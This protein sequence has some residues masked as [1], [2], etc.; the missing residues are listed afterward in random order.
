MTNEP[1]YDEDI[2]NLGYLN[3]VIEDTEESINIEYE[4]VSR[5]YGSQ[6]VPP[7]YKGDTWI[8]G[9][10]VYTCI[11]DR[12]IGT[13]QSS[14]WTTESG[15]KE[16]AS[17]KN[18]V[19]LAQPSN[20]RP[21]DMWI[22]QTDSD[23]IAGKKGEM[24][25]STFGRSTYNASD[26]INMLGYGKIISINEAI[27]N[28]NN[29]INTIIENIS[30]GTIT[31]FYSNS[32][33][34]N[35]ITNDLWYVTG[36]VQGYEENKLYKYNGS[37]WVWVDNVYIL[38][39]FEEVNEERLV[40]DGKIQSFYSNT[41][42]TNNLGVGDL[43][44][45]LAHNNKLYRY[46]GTNWVE[47]YETNLVATEKDMEEITQRTTSIE[48][49]LGT[50]D[51]KVTQNTTA[52]EKIT[53]TYETKQNASQKY[54]EIKIET[55]KID[56]KVAKDDVIGS[57]NLSSEEASI[58]ASKINLNGV[59]TANNNF[60]ILQDGSM[61]ARNAKY[62]GG[63]VE[64]YSANKYETSGTGEEIKEEDMG[65]TSVLI[66]ANDE[67]SLVRTDIFPDTI[68]IKGKAGTSELK[69]TGPNNSLD[70][71]SYG[72]YYD[73]EEKLKTI[74][75][76]EIKTN[77]HPW[78]YAYE[79]NI[80]DPDNPFSSGIERVILDGMDCRPTLNLEWMYDT[81]GS[82]G[83]L[84]RAVASKTPSFMVSNYSSYDGIDFWGNV[85]G[86]LA[87]GITINPSSVEITSRDGTEPSFYIDN[88]SYKMCFMIG[89][90]G[91]NR[92][93]YDRTQGFWVLYRDANHTYLQSN[94]H[95]IYLRPN[96]NGTK[97]VVINSDGV[98]TVNNNILLNGEYFIQGVSSSKTINLI[99]ASGGVCAIGDSSVQTGIW[100]TSVDIKNALSVGGNITPKSNL[101]YNLG[102]SSNAFNAVYT[103]EIY[104]KGIGASIL[105]GV[106]SSN[107]YV[108]T[109]G[110]Q[111]DKVTNIRGNT[112]RLYAHSGGGVYLGSS[113][114]TAI[115]SDE[116][117]KNI[118]DF[119]EKY[120]DFFMNLKPISY[121]YKNN[122]HRSHL[123]FGARQVEQ[124]LLD[125]NLTTEDFAGIL[126]DTDVTI[127]ADEAG[128]K[129]DVHYDELYSLRYEEFI[130]LNTAMTQKQAK[131]IEEQQKQIND[132]EKR[133]SKLE[134]GK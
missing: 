55:D 32:V 107:L 122:G 114:S 77:A 74:G 45:D 101:S 117:L 6:P 84:I 127:G 7:Y 65:T 47:V 26:W 125:A 40:S 121:V 91:V 37:S 58:N 100:G 89:S 93:I 119:N 30:A 131:I 98:L 59:V 79:K 3:R 103:N 53:D 23:H 128:T 72:S 29:A 35:M 19:F 81:I 44:I 41:E 94:G 46:N 33:P 67:D 78:T 92:G 43:W 99:R 64:L 18:K 17:N 39:A 134:K 124:A 112:V 27:N 61:E 1:K 49:D 31:V 109:G 83:S 88:D 68:R 104:A 75:K 8:D 96:N 57:I 71:F 5:H 52:I 22:L 24:L 9:N 132:L 110:G 76:A 62:T 120:L 66:V 108:G 85:N 36:Q 105:S 20:Y 115:T 70:I 63:R 25:I 90:G 113:G 50:I 130:A 118:Y 95:N 80:T 97:Q 123:G 73:G 12:K 2:V 60:K 13:Y 102:S 56:L 69:T 106:N 116:N 129:E 42:P 54:A 86:T 51:L 82:K 15:A 10:T 38:K 14:D 87:A 48:T 111:K 133:I 21:G 34:E 28:L 11:Q 4:N 126:K 16:L